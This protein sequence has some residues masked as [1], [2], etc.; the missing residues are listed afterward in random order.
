MVG[1]G[2]GTVQRVKGERPHG[3]YSPTGTIQLPL[4]RPSNRAGSTVGRSS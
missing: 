1:C 4:S 3:S 2:V